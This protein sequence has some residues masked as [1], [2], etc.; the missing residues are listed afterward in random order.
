MEIVQPI[1][2]I[3]NLSN[4]IDSP[5]LKWIFVGGKGGVGKTSVSTSLAVLL[6]QKREKILIISTDPA[7]NLSDAFNQKMGAQ[8]TLINGFN[9]LYGLEIN[10]KEIKDEEDDPLSDV[11]GVPLDD[12][13]QNLF[14]DLKN[15]IPGIDEALAIGLLLQVIDKMNYSLVIFDTAPTGHTLRMLSF[16]KVL[17]E[18]FGKLNALKEKIGPM[19]GLLAST[20][21]EGFKNLN[22]M[23]SV[24]KVQIEKI[25]A[26][27]TNT[28]HTTFIAVCIP[29]FLSM[30]ETE[31]LIQELNKGKIDC[32][33]IVINQVLFVNKE[34]DNCECDMCKAR[35]KM[36]SKYIRQI[37]ELYGEEEKDNDEEDIN[38]NVINEE[39]KNNSKYYISILPL[40]E[41]EIRGIDLLKKFGQFLIKKS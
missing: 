18:A 24:F 20:L 6:S 31:R 22:E 30:Y 10:P 32:H 11:L 34:N 14:E 4:I 28:S 39:N 5:T 15:S 8:P 12:E 21:G 38:M 3:G 17:D 1:L 16:P 26:D 13:T 23:I 40:Q 35:F 33:N 7:H 27:F 19:S 41:E 37:Q 29:E 25:R 2:P 36:Q 9:N